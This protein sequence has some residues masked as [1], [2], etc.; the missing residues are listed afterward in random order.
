MA[1]AIA[2]W[3]GPVLTP[4]IQYQEQNV[5]AK[6]VGAVVIVQFQ[7]RML[8]VL[9]VLVVHLNHAVVMVYVQ[10]LKA[11]V[12]RHGVHAKVNPGVIQVGTGVIVLLLLKK[13]VHRW[14]AINMATRKKTL[15]LPAVAKVCVC[16]RVNVAATQ[17]MVASIVKMHRTVQCMPSVPRVYIRLLSKPDSVHSMVNV[18]WTV[19]VFVDR[20]GVVLRAMYKCPLEKMDNQ[21]LNAQTI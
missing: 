8:L 10:C 21:K 3:M 20:V 17:V 12:N 11:C 14:W 16:L 7:V 18:V 4:Q 19:L 2:M 1:M 5:V 6:R 9:G 13:C 15:V